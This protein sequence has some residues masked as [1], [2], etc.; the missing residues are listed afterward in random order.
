MADY[1]MSPVVNVRCYSVV[2]TDRRNTLSLREK[3]ECDDG[4]EISSWFYHSREDGVMGSLEAGRVAESDRTSVW[5]AII[6]DLFSGGTA[7]WDSSCRAAALQAGIDAG[8]ARGDLQ[9]YYGTSIGAI[10]GK[11]AG[12]LTLDGKSGNEPKWRL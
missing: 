8:G 3:M 2:S 6:V 9:G 11:V 4:S 5:Q 7:W 12:P 1:G 10:D